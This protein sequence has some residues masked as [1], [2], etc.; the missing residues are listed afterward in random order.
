MCGYTIIEKNIAEQVPQEDIY[1]SFDRHKLHI[2]C[3]GLRDIDL[4]VGKIQPKKCYSTFDIS[5]D[6]FE[7]VKTDPI[8]I[9]N[10]GININKL[11]SLDIDIPHN[12]H[13]C[14]MLDICAWDVSDEKGGM[15]N[16]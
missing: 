13:F 9:K 12:K 2:F 3:I 4:E 14:P 10:G 6:E 11:I 1:P 7:P 15:A 8:K 5:G 16:K